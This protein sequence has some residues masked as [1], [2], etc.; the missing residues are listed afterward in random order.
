MNSPW[1]THEK[2]KETTSILLL[3]LFPVGSLLV[4]QHKYDI[5][6]LPPGK[7]ETLIVPE[8]C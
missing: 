1:N 5:V 7:A 6:E 2:L 8:N 4:N 3:P